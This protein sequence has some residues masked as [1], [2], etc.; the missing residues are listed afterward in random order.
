MGIIFHKKTYLNILVAN[1]GCVTN[2]EI[3]DK[4][5]PVK[6]KIILASYKAESLSKNVFDKKILKCREF[7]AL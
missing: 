7:D 5:L 4:E 3:G 6:V 2:A 1:W